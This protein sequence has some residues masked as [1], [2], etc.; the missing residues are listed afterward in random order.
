MLTLKQ[1]RQYNRFKK[2]SVFF[3]AN[4][5]LIA[6]F[7]PFQTEV[8]NF[9]LNL[10]SLDA[11]VPDTDGI[12]TGI[13]SEKTALKQ[14]IADALAM[15]CKKT[16]AYALINDLSQLA[17]VTNIGANKIFKMKDADIHGFALT[18]ET[19]ITPVLADPAFATYNITAATLTAIVTDA[20][21]FTGMIG[22]AETADSIIT[23]ASTS[24]NNFIKAII[25]NISHFDLLINEFES[26]HPA[27]VQEYYINS[28]PDITGIHH[29]GIKGTVTDKATGLAITNATITVSAA[30]KKDK[31]TTTDMNGAYN[32][33][34]INAG[35]YTITVTAEGFAT[36]TIVHKIVRGKI[37][38]MDFAL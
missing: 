13:T 28:S 18:I 32:L 5:T 9:F 25:I 35:D 21:T 33:R 1:S 23:I 19:I 12:T 26:M 20:T 38:E 27:F 24:I 37:D 17:A 10:Q 4:N 7:A 22:K 16:R 11:L 29:N 2:L 3:T 31:T 14:H 30:N 15:V 36:Q 6:S 34:S 8:N